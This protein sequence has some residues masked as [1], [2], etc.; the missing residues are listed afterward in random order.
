M[1][2]I[3]AA[4]NLV[5]QY[6]SITLEQLKS[7]FEK[8]DDNSWQPVLSAIT[9]FGDYHT[10]QLC[11]EAR[12]ITNSND[13]RIFCKACVYNDHHF[14]MFYCI[15]DTYKDICDAESAEELYAAIQNRITYLK[16][17]IMHL[18]LKELKNDIYSVPIPSNWREGQFVFNR[19]EELYGRVARE[20]QFEDKVDCF[21]RDEEIDNFLVCVFNRLIK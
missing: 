11:K 2:N 9:G 17:T 20:V 16:Q 12:T 1:I 4:R 18:T 10:C 3:N 14:D 15:D 7:N 19:V 5:Q 6:E 21:Y 8:A 13:P